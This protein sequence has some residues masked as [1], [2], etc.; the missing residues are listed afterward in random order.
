MAVKQYSL[1]KDGAALL[2]PSFHVRELRCR[3]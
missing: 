2:A 3:D 1:A